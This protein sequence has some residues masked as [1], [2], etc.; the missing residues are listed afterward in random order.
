MAGV[1]GGSAGY[2]TVNPTQGNP[3]GD[4]LANVENSAFRYRAEK[5]EEDQLKAQAARQLQ[6]DRRRDMEDSYKFSKDNPFIATGTGLDAVNRQSYMNAKDTAAKAYAEYLKTGD[7]KHRAVYENAVAS[8]NNISAF[9]KQINALKE[10]WV[11]NAGSYNA[12]SLKRKAALLDQI[13]SGQI[14]QTNDANGNPKYTVFDR[15]ETGNINKLAHKDLNSDQLLKL[16]TP[17]KGFNI[18]GKDGFID[19][20]NKNIGK[21]RK[22]IEGT[23]LNAVEKTYNPGAED[24]AKI[25]ANDAVNDRSKMYETLQRMGMD[26]EDSK[27]YTDDTVKKAAATYLEKMLM[28]TA[29]TTV[30]KK[31]D[32]SIEMLNL[33]RT[34]EY[35]DERQRNITNSREAR[36]EAREE[37]NGT[38]WGQVQTVKQG[39]SNRNTGIKVS[40]GDK[41]IQVVSEGK[42]DKTGASQATKAIAVHQ[43]GNI[44]VAID[45]NVGTDP[46]TFEPKIK[47]VTY[48]TKTNMGGVERALI[49]LETND[50]VKITNLKQ[51]KA[52]IKSYAGVPEKPKAAPKPAA[53]K[54]ETAKKYSSIEEKAIAT[55]MKNNPGYSREEIISALKLK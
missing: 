45:K 52:F 7:M 5:R 51:A 34:K 20:F 49:G 44:S 31:P 4:A 50:G 47:Q 1:I 53:P 46:M 2:A 27:N 41:V 17:E 14:V 38:T 22:V 10:D 6:E 42:K 55:A 3:I 28:V 15:D 13:A 19:L 35:N 12:E 32:T 24:L 29:P 16:L 23:G 43:D 40:I 37:G 30:S 25:M 21:E 33:A 11:K 48:N 26:P 36:K 9:P 39:D 8:V 18:D 54:K